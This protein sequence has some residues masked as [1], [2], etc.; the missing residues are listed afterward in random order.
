MYL[1]IW[2]TNNISGCSLKHLWWR[3][4]NILLCWNIL[5][6]WIDVLPLDVVLLWYAQGDLSESVSVQILGFNAFNISGV[7]WKIDKKNTWDFS[8]G[9]VFLERDI[10][11]VYFVWDVATVAWDNVLESLTFEHGFSIDGKLQ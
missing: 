3:N 5:V 10:F 7:S 1:F 8:S 9:F 6:F 4:V 11:F 2:N